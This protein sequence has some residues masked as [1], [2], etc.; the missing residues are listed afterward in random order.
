MD[1]DIEKEISWLNEL[2]PT[3]D[4][5]RLEARPPT[6]LVVVHG[7]TVEVLSERSFILRT[8]VRA[9]CA[10]RPCVIHAPTDH[11]MSAMPL[12][13][14]WDRGIFERSCA[15]GVGHPDPD[16]EAYWRESGGQ[17][18]VESEMVHGC[19]GQ[20]CCVPTNPN[21]DQL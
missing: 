17:A 1:Y 5:P 20:G 7:S 11:S 4:G 10:G 3:D 6:D 21:S 8:H 14:R 9:E 18:R 16:Q 2:G 19:C 15:H 12:I 13:W